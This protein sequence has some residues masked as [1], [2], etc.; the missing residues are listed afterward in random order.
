MVDLATGT[1]FLDKWVSG[2]SG[3]AI[4]RRAT[5]LVWV[6][7][8]WAAHHLRSL[9]DQLDIHRVLVQS[10][11]LRVIEPET[12][13]GGTTSAYLWKT[14]ALRCPYGRHAGL[15]VGPTAIPGSTGALEGS[16]TGRVMAVLPTSAQPRGE[17]RQVIS[18]FEASTDD[19]DSFTNGALPLKWRPRVHHRR[20]TRQAHQ[21]DRTPTH[22]GRSA[23]PT[24][25]SRLP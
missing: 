13:T 1:R 9:H 5:S 22:C 16:R 20:S 23:H 4:S 6:S 24:R 3:A 10:N 18:R 12:T 17:P 14:A 25:S 7:S 2:P 19:P 21:L 8:P 15:A 11:L